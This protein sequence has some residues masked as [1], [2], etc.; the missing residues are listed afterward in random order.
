MAAYGRFVYGR[1]TAADTASALS[2]ALAEPLES[3]DEIQEHYPFTHHQLDALLVATELHDYE[4][5][6][7][8]W[9]QGDLPS[10][11]EYVLNDGLPQFRERDFEGEYLEAFRREFGEQADVRQRARQVVEIA[12]Q[13]IRSPGPFQW[14]RLRGIAERIDMGS[15]NA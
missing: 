10:E 3:L 4:I 11:E 7:M 13:S 1:G 12:E 6:K 15:P 2:R 8:L 14:E 5:E 9:Q